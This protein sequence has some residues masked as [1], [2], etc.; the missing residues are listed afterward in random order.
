MSNFN[1]FVF[2]RALFSV[3]ETLNFNFI[4]VDFKF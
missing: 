4:D 3:P 2:Y 1:T